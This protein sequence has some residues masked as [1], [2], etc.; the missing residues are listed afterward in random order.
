MKEPALEIKNISVIRA[1]KR[2]L[3]DVSLSAYP[4][5]I[6]AVIGCNGSGKS[7]LAKSIFGAV[8]IDEG[9]IFV[10]G[11]ISRIHSPADAMR[12][13]IFMCMQEP[14]LLENRTVTDNLFIRQYSSA[15]SPI[16]NKF[17]V[18]QEAQNILK[19]FRIS[20]SPQSPVRILSQSEKYLLQFARCLISNPQ[21]LILDEI[22]ATIP[23]RERAL[24]FDTLKECKAKQ[25][26][27]L[28]ITHNIEEVLAIA[29]RVTVLKEGRAVHSFGTGQMQSEL[30]L[31]AMLGD[32]DRKPYP[33]LPIKKGNTL[34]EVSHIENRFIH[35][36]TFQVH[37]GE[38]IGIA[39][40]SSSGRTKLLQTL[41]G[42][43]PINAGDIIYP[44][45]RSQLHPLQSG[46]IIGYIPEDRDRFALFQTLSSAK[47][48]TI[49]NL[50]KI[51]KNSVLKL[52]QEDAIAS[53]F[54]RRL[55]I[56]NSDGGI[57]HMSNG[58]KQKIVVSQCLHSHCRIYIF[59]E[60]TQ[61]IDIVGKVEIYNLMNELALNG[62]GIIMVSSDFS[63]LIHMCD[64]ILV[65]Q[66]GTM[67]ADLAANTLSQKSLLEYFI[68]PQSSP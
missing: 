40:F 31:Q 20:A 62:A 48:I 43:E 6:H 51:S 17:K 61:S 64:R 1:K 12:H 63:E 67:I 46:N 35:D 5:E 36:F 47:N 28:Y 18:R 53:S 37:E 7:L 42:L 11:K 26:S 39:G 25:I 27:I 15:H 33:K 60:P 23:P 4:G 38:I 55:N 8:P 13:G 29:D 32:S 10:N 65:I 30:L 2:F 3:H 56:K 9:Q 58:N 52:R 44:D 66:N 57:K 34:L 19:R 50:K 21:I 45:I 68:P 16:I 41:A 22:T 49:R 54:I 14:N 59:D 24:I